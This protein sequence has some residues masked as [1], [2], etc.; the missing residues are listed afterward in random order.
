MGNE[1]RKVRSDSRHGELVQSVRMP[2]DGRLLL[3]T[4]TRRSVG[5]DQAT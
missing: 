4:H 1:D 3:Q 2:Q 5:T